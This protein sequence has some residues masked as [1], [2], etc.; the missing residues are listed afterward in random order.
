VGP[1]RRFG[2]GIVHDTLPRGTPARFIPKH[3]GA[4]LR[5]RPSLPDF[6]HRRHHRAKD[7]VPTSLL[8]SLFLAITNHHSHILT[9]LQHITTSPSQHITLCQQALTAVPASEL[10]AITELLAQTS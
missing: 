2:R 5:I 7:I 4:L 10:A 6:S 1:L 8:V 9:I 3:P